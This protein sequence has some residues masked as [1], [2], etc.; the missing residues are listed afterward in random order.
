MIGA[1]VFSGLY[2]KYHMVKYN[3]KANALILSKHGLI[4]C[5]RMLYFTLA[6]H[7]S[8]LSKRKYTQNEGI[9]VKLYL[10][11]RRAETTEFTH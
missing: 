10:V 2:W 7:G 8:L 4:Y 3:Q 9:H 6:N 5:T 1:F 11:L